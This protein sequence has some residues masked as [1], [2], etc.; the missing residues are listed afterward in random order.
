A[1]A[2]VADVA[3]KLAQEAQPLDVAVGD[4]PRQHDDLAL[5]E[6]EA[7]HVLDRAAL[8]EADRDDL[9][10]DLLRLARP[11]VAEARADV[12]PGPA[13][14][15]PGRRRPAHRLGDILAGRFADDDQFEV[16]VP[17]DVAMVLVKRRAGRQQDHEQRDRAAP[18]SGTEPAHTALLS[19]RPK[20]SMR[21]TTCRCRPS[22]TKPPPPPVR[23]AGGRP[24]P[25][26]PR[27]SPTPSAWPPCPRASPPVSTSGPDPTLR[28]PSRRT[29]G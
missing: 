11:E 10:V 27:P 13:G 24:C 22:R 9:P 1:G 4:T 7:L 12:V 28:R 19:C 29:S 26:T 14:E 21:L 25:M 18:N 8:V 23:T 5:L 17:R 3:E 15:K 16:G 2:D 20:P 6:P